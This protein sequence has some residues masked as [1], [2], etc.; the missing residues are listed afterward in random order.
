MN[1]HGPEREQRPR[2]PHAPGRATSPT[3]A[4]PKYSAHTEHDRPLG[5]ATTPRPTPEPQQPRQPPP[6]RRGC[7]TSGYFT[8]LQMPQ[9]RDVNNSLAC[10]VTVIA[11]AD[12]ANWL[13]MIFPPMVVRS[14]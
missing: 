7:F 9:S 13:S 2:A 12:V 8:S 14:Q 6:G 11:F 5:A 10:T 1:M 3:H 4:L